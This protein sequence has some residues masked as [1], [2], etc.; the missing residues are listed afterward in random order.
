M[1]QE[2]DQAEHGQ[3]GAILRRRGVNR[4][5]LRDWRNQYHEGGMAALAGKTTSKAAS[6]GSADREARRLEE[7]NERLRTDVEKYKTLA[8]IAGNSYALL[9]L[10]SESADSE[11]R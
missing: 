10:L 6:A 7:E 8:Q 4:T 1:I 2:C 3:I 9:E 11:T 5:H